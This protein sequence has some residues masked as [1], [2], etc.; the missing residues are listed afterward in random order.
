MGLQ[1]VIKVILPAGFGSQM[2]GK[3]TSGR[4]PI[5]KM[6]N[7]KYEKCQMRYGKLWK[8]ALPHLRELGL[9]PTGLLRAA[10]EAPPQ[11]RPTVH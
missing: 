4:I 9:A 3:T 5:T 10:A 2:T 6:T 8:M 7:E 11:P 1:S